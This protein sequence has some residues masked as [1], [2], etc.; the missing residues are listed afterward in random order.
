MAE[1]VIVLVHVVWT[2]SK[3]P[4]WMLTRFVIRFAII[5]WLIDLSTNEWIHCWHKQAIFLDWCCLFSLSAWFCKQSNVA[6]VFG[7]GFSWM[8]LDSYRGATTLL[9]LLA[10][11]L[12]ATAARHLGA[13][14]RKYIYQYINYIIG[15]SLLHLIVILNCMITIIKKPF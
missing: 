3:L 8:W 1:I 4:Y 5:G 15:P 12:I 14:K 11:H 10:L 13:N 7:R 9:A 6:M 2:I